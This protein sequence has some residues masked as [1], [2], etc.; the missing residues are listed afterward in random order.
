MRFF[1]LR[2]LGLGLFFVFQIMGTS[3]AAN[4]TIQN[5]GIYDVETS[6]K[7]VHKEGDVDKIQK[8]VL[9]KE[10]DEIPAYPGTHFG[11]EYFLDEEGVVPTK[12][13]ITSYYREGSGE[14]RKVV[15]AEIPLTVKSGQKHYL[16]WNLQQDE[17]K[18]SVWEFK[19]G[20]PF[21]KF[22]SF[23]VVP[24]RKPEAGGGD[25]SPAPGGHVTRYLVRDG[26]Y[27]KLREA[28]F[29]K[30]ELIK[31]GYNPFVFGRMHKNKRYYYHLFVSMHGTEKVAQRNLEEYMRAGN[32]DA[33]IEKAEISFD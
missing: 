18:F 33:E 6:P 19:F 24:L 32:S 16:G 23:N 3:S 1:D 8:Y 14:E 28:K 22:C 30:A 15:Q 17:L 12:V 31:Q 5:K 29:R 25:S 2:I 26:I 20:Y 9:S 11:F 7:M 27:F 21:T 10:T 13:I 4:L